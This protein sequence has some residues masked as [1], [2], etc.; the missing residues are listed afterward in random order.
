M[1]FWTLMMRH[2]HG[3][4]GFIWALLDESV[5]RAD[6]NGVL[7]GDGN[8]APDGILGPYREKEA[9]FFTIR[10]IW[11]PVFVHLISLPENFNGR[12]PAVEET[13][14]HLQT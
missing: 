6:K 5:Y 12:I 8:H 2:P 9:S 3:A 10:E 7:D 14:I 4:G 13:D 11:S 1:D